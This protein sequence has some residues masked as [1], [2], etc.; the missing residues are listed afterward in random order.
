M[1]E[2]LLKTIVYVAVGIVYILVNSLLKSKKL[3]SEVKTIRKVIK[4]AVEYVEQ[5]S[6]IEDLHGNQKKKYAKTVA[7]NMLKDL[8][9]NVSD[10]IIDTIIESMVFYMNLEKGDESNELE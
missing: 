10:G 6:K 4:H 9:I 5:V 8:H 7:K 1:E 3:E 2:V